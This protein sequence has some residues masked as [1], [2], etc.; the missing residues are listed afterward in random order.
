MLLQ[1]S[2]NSITFPVYIFGILKTEHLNS[3][4]DIGMLA[5]TESRRGEGMKRTDGEIMTENSA[6]NNMLVEGMRIKVLIGDKPIIYTGKLLKE[7]ED[8]LT[9]HDEHTNTPVKIYKENSSIR[10]EVL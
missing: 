2:D 4:Y 6:K 1:L 8:F 10:V 9:V 7:T 5:A 3:S